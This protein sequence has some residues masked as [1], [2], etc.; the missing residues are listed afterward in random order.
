[1]NTQSNSYTFIY[2]SIIVVIVATLLALI[3]SALKPA[4][5]KNVEIEKK[6]NILSSLRIATTRNDAE[7][8]YNEYIVDKFTINSKGEKVAGVDPFLVNMKEELKKEPS[9]RNL[10]VYVSKKT[11]LHL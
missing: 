11:I 6:Q 8:K 7:K 1:M 10:P 5:E 4:Q 3:A 2:S 9:E